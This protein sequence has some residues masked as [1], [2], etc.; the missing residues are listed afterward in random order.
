MIEITRTNNPLVTSWAIRNNGWIVG[1]IVL[2][3]GVYLVVRSKQKVLEIAHRART[4]EEAEAF[5]R[6][7]PEI[8][9][10]E[11]VARWMKFYGEMKDHENGNVA[12]SNRVD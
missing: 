1:H 9:I 10:E 3:L 11:F 4:F 12:V 8:P 7:K 5:V 2:S 6:R